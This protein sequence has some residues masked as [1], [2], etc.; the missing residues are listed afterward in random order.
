MNKSYSQLN[1]DLKVIKFYTGKKNGFFIDIGAHDGISL[2]NTYLLEKNYDWKGICI[3]PNPHVFKKLCINRPNTT[4]IDKLIYQKD[5]LNVIFS[6]IEGYHEMLSGIKKNIGHHANT[7]R[8]NK[9]KKELSMT[10]ISMKTL[11]KKYKN[12]VPKF[13]DYMSLDTEGSELEILKGFDF[14]KYK[15][16]IIDVE[17]NY[18]EP[19]RTDIKKYLESFGYIRLHKNNWDDSYVHK[20]IYQE[21]TMNDIVK[22]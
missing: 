9:N 17:H 2:S 11:L 19:R 12:I 13:I 1:Q 10:T 7:V 4:N 15:I 5:N 21:L 8:L 18:E 6:S 3:E 14:G 16:G 20:S 22:T